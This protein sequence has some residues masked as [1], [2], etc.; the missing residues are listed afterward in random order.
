MNKKIVQSV[1]II[2][3]LLCTLLGA[4]GVVLPVLPTTPFLL[5]AA[6]FFAR[7]SKRFHVWLTQS[8][9]YKKHLHS[10]V[11][12]RTMTLKT[13]LCILLPAS[14]MLIIAF[15]FAPIWHVQVLIAFAFVFK[16]YYFFFRIKT[17]PIEK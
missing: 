8:K 17:I 4:I 2:L 12:T 9:L 6:F 1:Y 13:K 3:G 16:Y 5:L 15:C 10:F 14:V 7:S 11:E